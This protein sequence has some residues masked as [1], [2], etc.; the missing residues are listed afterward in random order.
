MGKGKGKSKWETKFYDLIMPSRI[1]YSTNIG[2]YFMI[3]NTQR[4][5]K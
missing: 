5:K 3:R 1:L 2:I 4:R